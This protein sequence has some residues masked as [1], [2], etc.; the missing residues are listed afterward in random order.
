L[1]FKAD[2]ARAYNLLVVSDDSSGSLVRNLSYDPAARKFTFDS[3]VSKRIAARMSPLV[4]YEATLEREGSELVRVV[5]PGTPY[6]AVVVD[7]VFVLV[8]VPSDDSLT[9]HVLG[10]D[11]QERP[12]KNAPGGGSG[13]DKPRH[14][15]DSTS[16][17]INRGPPP[18]PSGELRVN[19]GPS[20]SVILGA[21]FVLLGGVE[22][23]P[24]DDP[25]LAVLWRQIAADSASRAVIETPT[26]TQTRVTFPWPGF[27][28]FT[29]SAVFGNHRVEDTVLISVQPPPLPAFTDPN[30]LNPSSFAAYTEGP[31]FK[32]NWYA[33][34]PDTLD[35][36]LSRDSG[37]TWEGLSAGVVS[38]GPV[39][40]HWNAT[41]P[42]SENCFLKLKRTSTGKTVAYS[43]RFAVRAGSPPPKPSGSGH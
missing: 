27:Y 15:I 22:G 43:T 20:R 7:S 40:F 19:A 4:R 13:G 41:A 36:Q 30:P 26:A 2:S 5:A 37:A 33:Y 39:S 25:R 42:V 11:G 34:Q 32:I 17:P 35:L 6:Q 23:A 24:T 10:A 18:E 8:G 3:A 29:L 16:P 21:E 1:D 12:L 38:N 31:S 9:L 14:R 28:Y